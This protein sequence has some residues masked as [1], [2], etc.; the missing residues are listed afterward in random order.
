MGTSKIRPWIGAPL[1][2][3]FRAQYLFFRIEAHLRDW[4]G[5]A[6]RSQR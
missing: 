4:A 5:N 1:E 2:T 6:L 3:S